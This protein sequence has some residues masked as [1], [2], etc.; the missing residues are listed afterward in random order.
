ML[1]LTVIIVISIGF[2]GII[3]AHDFGKNCKRPAMRERVIGGERER[4]SERENNFK[5][6]QKRN[7]AIQLKSLSGGANENIR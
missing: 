1:V 6:K 3:A 4:K 2:A 7:C 5:Y